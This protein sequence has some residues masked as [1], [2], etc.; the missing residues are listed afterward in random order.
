MQQYKLI[1]SDYVAIIMR[2]MSYSKPASKELR[3]E[4]L[5]KGF[6]IGGGEYMS[7]SKTPAVSYGVIAFRISPDTQMPE[8]LMIRRKHTLG[9]MDFVRGKMPLAHKRYLLQMFNQMSAS[10]KHDLCELAKTPG[11]CHKEKIATLMRGVQSKSGEWYNTTSLVL[12]SNQYGVWSEPEWGFPKGKR[13]ASESDYACSVR[14]FTEET[15]FPISMFQHISTTNSIEEIFVGSNLKTYKH[16]YLAMF[17]PYQR[18]TTLNMSGFQSSE[19]SA[20]R[21][22]DYSECM[23]SIRGYNVE[24]KNMLETLH[25]EL[26]QNLNSR[27]FSRYY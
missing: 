26:C 25:E 11:E 21:W 20:M 22:M 3:I 9:Y 12:E 2:T 19:V 27:L 24:K 1:Q 8:Y 6:N 23:K 4:P 17:I 10:E 14:E 16:K 13:N 15:G 5:R 7:P 18:T